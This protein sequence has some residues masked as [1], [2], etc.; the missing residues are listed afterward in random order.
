VVNPEIAEFERYFSKRAS[1][2]PL[3]GY[4]REILRAYLW[5]KLMEDGDGR[6]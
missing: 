6:T 1:G 2:G 5:F 3:A 4:E